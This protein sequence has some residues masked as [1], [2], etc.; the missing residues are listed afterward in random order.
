MSPVS[1]ETLVASS[2]VGAVAVQRQDH[3][4]RDP[5]QRAYARF[6]RRL[7]RRGLARH[8]W[9]GPHAYAERAAQRADLDRLL[10]EVSRG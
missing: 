1:A 9:E 8:P 4:R 7:A 3:H 5:V 10:E 6:C 2:I